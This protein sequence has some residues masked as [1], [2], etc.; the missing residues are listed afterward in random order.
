MSNPETD[1][2]VPIPQIAL[3]QWAEI[4]ASNVTNMFDRLTVQHIANSHECCELV[5]WL[6]DHPEEYRRGVMRGFVGVEDKEEVE[7]DAS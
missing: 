2:R 1:K 4:R 7:S 6:E 3:D 5:C